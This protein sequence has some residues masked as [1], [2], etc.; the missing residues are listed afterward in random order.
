MPTIAP[1]PIAKAAAPIPAVAKIATPKPKA[2]IPNPPVTKAT[3]A[4]HP[5]PG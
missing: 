1:R 4:D 3:P 2:A 5:K